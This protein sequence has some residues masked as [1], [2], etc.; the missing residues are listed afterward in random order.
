MTEMTDQIAGSMPFARTLGVEIDSAGPDEVT[1]RLAWAAERC[2][3]GGVMH[4]GALMTLADSLGAA[5]AFLNLPA[6][7]STTTLESK[8]NFFRGVRDG[9]VRGVARPLHAGRRFIV[10]QTDLY[11]GRERRVA[12]V[13]Q[14]QAVLTDE[15]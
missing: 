3:A 1:G 7:A 12:Q 4:G 14:T 9:E 10:V 8:T 11:D 13:T 6:G 15:K 5:C 2:T